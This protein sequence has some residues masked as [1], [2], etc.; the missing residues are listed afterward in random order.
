MPQMNEWKCSQN[1]FH[2]DMVVSPRD[3]MVGQVQIVRLE[4]G[5]DCDSPS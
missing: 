5:A 1:M 4:R 2:S 3:V